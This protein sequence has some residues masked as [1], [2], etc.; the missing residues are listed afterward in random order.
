MKSTIP[1]RVIVNAVEEASDECDMPEG[2]DETFIEE[3]CELY[4]E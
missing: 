2:W 3:F 1:R 4:Y